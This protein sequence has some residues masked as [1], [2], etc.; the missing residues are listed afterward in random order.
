MVVAETAVA[1]R[2]GMKQK[3]NASLMILICLICF[4]HHEDVKLAA[5]CQSVKALSINIC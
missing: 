4:Y 3:K 5:A 1:Y 2:L